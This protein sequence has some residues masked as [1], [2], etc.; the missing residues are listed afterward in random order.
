MKRMRTRII[1]LLVLAV[2]L[3]G[4][5]PTA[6]FAAVLP[7]GVKVGDVIEFGTYEQ[8][9]NDSNGAEPIRWQVLEIRDGRALVISRYALDCKPY[10]TDRVE[11]T[12]ETSSLRKWLNEDFLSRAFTAEEQKN[13]ASAV[14]PNPKNP[15]YGTDGG[16][17]TTDRVFLLS[18]DEAQTYFSTNELRRVTPTAYAFAQGA[19]TSVQEYS[20]DA[21]CGWWLRS[22]GYI[23]YSAGCVTLNGAVYLQGDDVYNSIYGIRP[24]M[25]IGDGAGSETVTVAPAEKADEAAADGAASYAGIKVGDTIEFGSYEQD[26]NTANGA[27][28]IEW[29]VLDIQD[30]KALISSKY[31]LDSKP[32]HEEY[33]PVTWEDSTL[34]A[35][36]NNEFISTAFTAQEQATI[37]SVRIKNDANPFYGTDGGSDTT[38]R[39]FLLST[40][41]IEQY[42]PNKADRLVCPTR[43]AF[44]QGAWTYDKAA[45]EAYW[46]GFDDAASREYHAGASCWRWLRSPGY[47]S[48]FAMFCRNDGDVTKGGEIVTVDFITVCPVMW[49]E[50]ETPKEISKD[51]RV[52]D[53]IVFG[54]YEQDNNA[55]NGAEP[56]QWQVLEIQDGKALIISKYGLDCQ[57][58]NE[59]Y[60]AVTWESCT[61]RKW[62]NQDFLNKA[63]TKQEQEKIVET[64]VKNDVNPFYGTDGGSDTTDR[65]FLLSTEEVDR[66]FPAN[67]ERIVYATEYAF[68]QGVWTYDLATDESYWL[69]YRDAADQEYHSDASCWWWL[70]SP[71]YISIFAMFC[72]NDGH[73]LKGGEINSTGFASV[74]PVLWIE[75]PG[76]KASYTTQSLMIDG[77]EQT[78]EAYR[79]DGQSYVKLRDVAAL[80]SGT[81]AQFSV[82]CDG[83]T[84]AILIETGKA[85]ERVGT[86]LALGVDRSAGFTAVTNPVYVN[87]TLRK[88]NG[89]IFGGSSFFRLDDLAA[90]LGF[91]AV[92][93]AAGSAVTITTK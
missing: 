6:A 25:W 4:M 64:T 91:R 87:G 83:S 33:T 10:N 38:D 49:I 54:A 86:E 82:V 89:F 35:W 40:A 66:Y 67:D 3:I 31:A 92:S 7:A 32:Y 59:K 88:L 26:N 90:V 85:Y 46:M 36:L 75:C 60:A 70:R 14:V 43:Y 61:L 56:I 51:T 72:R 17:E 19:Y 39:V 80:L 57:P 21:Y 2:M 55:A 65:V 53:T 58:Y 24:V 84:G 18:I 28:P 30:G 81:Q 48:I 29:E 9:N 42:Y 50:L 34:R 47:I 11:M 62:L 1:A 13:I 77:V 52:G 5:L 41:E 69:G 93:D 15:S 78:V 76:Q 44:A 22:P 27:E 79:V 73:V 71:G 74:R 68:A 23:S 16:K 12:W 8:D 20:S 45:G 63:F 37:A